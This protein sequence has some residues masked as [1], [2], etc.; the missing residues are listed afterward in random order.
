MENQYLKNIKK[1]MKVEILTKQ[2]KIAKGIVEDLASRDSFNT[3]GITVRLKT[4]EIGRVQKIILNDE[5]KNKKNMQEI[6]T[7]IKNG[8]SLHVEFK[9]SCLWSLNISDQE[10][11]QTK[12]YD[13]HTFKQKAS[14]VIIARSIAAFLNSE[15]GNLVIGVKEK[16]G[17]N[18]KMSHDFE[19]IGIK[20]EFKKLKDP[21]IDGY[22]R[23]IM[24][25]ILR[26]YF[27]SKIYN[28]LNDYMMME[29]VEFELNNENKILCFIKIKKSDLKV[30]LDLTGKKIFMIRTDTE[31]RMLEGEELVDYCMKRFK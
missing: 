13:L 18:D 20:E 19:I 4:G 27:P 9:S 2:N 10:I 30:F 14:K 29:F 23:M 7:L 8:E 24:D 22:K 16:K 11:K 31:N 1:G 12:S 25:E 21:N 17:E 6:E 26:S 15:G 28:H 3:Y 5:E